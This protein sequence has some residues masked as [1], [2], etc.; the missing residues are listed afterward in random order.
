MELGRLQIELCDPLLGMQTLV[1]LVLINTLIAQ[2]VDITSNVIM[3]C[4]CILSEHPIAENITIFLAISINIISL[5]HVFFLLFTVIIK[6]VCIYF[7]SIQELVQ[8]NKVIKIIWIFSSIS[9]I[10]LVSMEFFFI[11]DVQSSTGSSMWKKMNL[12]KK[13]YFFFSFFATFV[14][15]KISQKIWFLSRIFE[16]FGGIKNQ[17]VYVIEMEKKSKEKK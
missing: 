5:I 12:S 4:W 6:Y 3:T 13:C 14:H 8:D 7:S 16:F 10:I 15:L 2:S 11:R 1:D 17:D 9:S